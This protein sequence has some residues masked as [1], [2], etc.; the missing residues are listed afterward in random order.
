V[1]SKFII[2]FYIFCS[3]PPLEQNKYLIIFFSLTAHLPIQDVSGDAQTTFWCCPFNRIQNGHT[4]DAAHYR[5]WVLLKWAAY[6]HFWCCPFDRTQNGHIFLMLPMCNRTQNGHTFWCCPFNRTH[7]KWTHFGATHYIDFLGP[8]KDG[9]HQNV[10]G[11]QS[12]NFCLRKKKKKMESRHGQTRK[13]KKA[14]CNS[15]LFVYCLQ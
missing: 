13:K 2:R 3:H 8:V 1:R 9:Q 14:A 12:I 7:P 6:T 10:S 15:T 4:F 5:L 11:H